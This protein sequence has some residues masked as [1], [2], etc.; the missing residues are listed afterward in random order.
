MQQI[1]YTARKY[2]LSCQGG[3]AGIANNENIERICVGSVVEE[4]TFPSSSRT[5]R[6][7]SFRR[8]SGRGAVIVK[9][10]INPEMV[11]D[12][13]KAQQETLGPNRRMTVDR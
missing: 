12:G 9:Q 5:K 2:W 7:S 13:K 8:W 11:P 6:R 10:P 3:T 1:F 4:V